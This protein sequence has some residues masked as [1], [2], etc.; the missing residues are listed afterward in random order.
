MTI[1]TIIT[2]TGLAAMMLA[3]F[4][5]AAA[6]AKPHRHLQRPFFEFEDYP[7]GQHCM[8]FGHALHC[9]EPR[10]G[11][12]N[13]IMRRDPGYYS[14]SNDPFDP[15]YRVYN[16]DPGYSFSHRLSCGEARERVRSLGF[17]KVVSKDCS[18]KSYS[19]TG[20]KRGHRYLVKVNAHTGRVKPYAM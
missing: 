3:G 15:G 1:R 19:F 10:W 13:H 7:F 6:E 5:G 2:A 11:G 4:G 17:K 16:D 20:S 14:W 8:R 18:G 9:S 12:T